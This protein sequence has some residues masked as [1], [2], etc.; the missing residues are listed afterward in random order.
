MPF[1]EGKQSC[2]T[3]TLN[4][5]ASGNSNIGCSATQGGERSA[6]PRGR[7]TGM[8][9]SRCPTRLQVKIS[10]AAGK[11]RWAWP[12]GSGSSC[13]GRW[14]G[15]ICPLVIWV[16]NGVRATRTAN[17]LIP[18]WIV[19]GFLRVFLALYLSLPRAVP[20][21]PRVGGDHAPR[22]SQ[23]PQGAHK[24]C[25]SFPAHISLPPPALDTLQNSVL[26]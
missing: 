18:L 1:R 10:Q 26:S 19:I 5:N 20:L 14:P 4:V 24:G 25:S 16:N 15:S 23:T 21:R 22:R 12:W 9:R 6:W 17:Y 8:S 11:W 7:H 2:R 3:E 13:S